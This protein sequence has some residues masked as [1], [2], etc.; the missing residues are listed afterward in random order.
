MMAAVPNYLSVPQ[1]ARK[2]NVSR[3]TVYRWIRN[4]DLDATI[5]GSTLFVREADVDKRLAA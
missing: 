5:I 2:L 4:G 1:A 3:H